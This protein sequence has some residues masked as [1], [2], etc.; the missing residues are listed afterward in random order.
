M[1]EA[2]LS[3]TREKI[4]FTSSI[5]FKFILIFILLV[6]VTTFLSGMIL[7]YQGQSS[8]EDAVLKKNLTACEN[9]RSKI[10]SFVQQAKSSVELMTLMPGIK[11]LDLFQIDKMM[12]EVIS[13]HEMLDPVAVLNEQGI[14]I[15]AR[16][17]ADQNKDMSGSDVFLKSKSKS[18]VSDVYFSADGQPLVTIASPVFD[19]DSFSRRIGVLVISVRLRSLWPLLDQTKVG[20]KGVIIVTDKEGELIYRTGETKTGN[21]GN[22]RTVKLALDGKTGSIN[23]G[24]MLSSY[25]PLAGKIKGA[26]AVKQP[27]QEALYGVAKMRSQSLVLLIMSIMVAI[28]IGLVLS[29]SML[30]SVRKLLIGTKI[31]GE[32]DLNYKIDIN[33]NDEI[34]ELARSFNAMTVELKKQR[35]RAITDELTHLYTHSYFLET[36]KAEVYRAKRYKSRLSLMMLDIDHFKSFND[37]YGHQVGDEVLIKISDMLKASLRESD[38][39]SR[40]GG[41]ELVVLATE[42]DKEGIYILAE[43]IRKK[44]AEDVVVEYDDK[45]LKVTI[46][47]GVTTLSE[48][49]MQHDIFPDDFLKRVD[50]ALYKAKDKGRNCVVQ[51]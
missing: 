1:A 19:Y 40:Y 39:A 3:S 34:G 21:L 7:I 25:L 12:Y 44:I 33:T 11:D 38:V 48:E 27:A 36:L 43:R 37:N 49:D 8:L 45:K 6:T 46:S 15:S 35:E 32:G 41:E 30:V 17:P 47:I 16:N 2:P 23:S 42:T 14:E 50:V 4:P 20:E 5:N 22:D 31:V 10:E 28:A 29:N 13:E 51:L 24:G 26:V 18:Y 9:V